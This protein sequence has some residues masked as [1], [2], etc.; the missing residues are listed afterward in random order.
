MRKQRLLIFT[1][2]TLAIFLSGQ[3]SLRAEE[4]ETTPASTDSYSIDC[5]EI[6]IVSEKNFA[7]KPDLIQRL[8]GCEKIFLPVPKN[9][10]QVQLWTELI[11]FLKTQGLEVVEIPVAYVVEKNNKDAKSDEDLGTYT[12]LEDK[13]FFHGNINDISVVMDLFQNPAPR[14]DIRVTLLFTDHYNAWSWELSFVNPMSIKKFKNRLTA[15]I[16]TRHFN[17]AL[18]VSGRKMMT[19]WNEDLLKNEYLAKGIDHIEGIYENITLGDAKYKVGV[20]EVS[21]NLYLIYLSGADNTAD[22]QEGEI[23][24]ILYPT[25]TPLLYK[26]VWIM[27]DK[28]ENHDS[29]IT[30]REGF[31]DTWVEEN[32]NNYLKI[33]PTI[34]ESKIT[35]IHKSNSGTGFAIGAAGLIV[36]N[37]HVIQG[38]QVIKV[39]GVNGDFSKVYHAKPLLVDANN[40]LAIIKIVDLSF[41]GLGAIPYKVK[42]KTSQVG[43]NIYVLGYPLRSSMGDELKLTNGIISSKTGFQ[44]DV[45]SYQISAPIQP[46]NSGGPLFDKE[47]NLIGIINAKHSGAENAT[48]AVKSSF[49]LNMMDLLDYSVNANANSINKMSLT[50]QVSLIRNFVYMIDTE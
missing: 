47:G 9:I 46:G 11:D 26:S 45:T 25:A 2:L 17:P 6:K 38:A 49:L 29:Y 34:N 16:G 35:A 42:S 33:Y 12:Y 39:R 3:V 48:Y 31:F 28:R 7:E 8:N 1:S 50:Q 27:S 24:A 13:N 4:H 21:G 5:N 43:E 10:S 30:F 14:A 32:K 23:K 19:C 15:E 22:W 18:K 40:D 36:T 41:T 37:Q 20:K 44:G